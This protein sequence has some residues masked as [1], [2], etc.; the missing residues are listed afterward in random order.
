MLNLFMRVEGY[1]KTV[2]QTQEGPRKRSKKVFPQRNTSKSCLMT[3]LLPIKHNKSLSEICV[4]HA[5][6][7]GMTQTMCNIANI[8]CFQ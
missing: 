8:L 3:I 1:I 5:N 4:R 2:H 7:L 6:L